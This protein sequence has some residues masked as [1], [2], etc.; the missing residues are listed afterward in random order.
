MIGLRWI[1]IV[2]S[3]VGTM[4]GDL[5]PSLGNGE[6]FVEWPFLGKKFHL[7][8][9]I[10]LTFFSHLVIDLF[11][12]PFPCLCCLTAWHHLIF[13]YNICHSFLYDKRLFHIT[14]N[15]RFFLF[16]LSHVSSIST[17][18]NIRGT[19]AWAVPTSNFWGTVPQ[20]PLCLRP[21]WAHNY[22]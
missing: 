17:S 21:W 13:W 14:K 16:V 10:L 19:D 18:P 15:F 20:S 2:V 9:K 22:D 11:L 5:A 8:P 12:L 7:T 6:K 1:V 3:L 4:G